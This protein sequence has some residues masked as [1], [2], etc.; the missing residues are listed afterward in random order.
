MGVV[1]E[2][3]EDSVSVGRISDHLVPRRDRQLAGDEGGAAPVTLFE[4]L[5]QIVAGERI[6]RFEPPYVDIR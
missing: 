3:V 6:E 5:E 1:D 2:A 4:D